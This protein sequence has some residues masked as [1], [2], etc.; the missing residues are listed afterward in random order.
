MGWCWTTNWKFPEGGC[1]RCLVCI[2]IAG[3]EHRQK[4]IVTRKKV[5]NSPT[6]SFVWLPAKELCFF[7]QM[8]QV[9][10]VISLELRGSFPSGICA[11]QTGC[12]GVCQ[13]VWVYVW[14]IFLL[15]IQWYAALMRVQVK[16]MGLCIL[17]SYG[18]IT[19]HSVYLYLIY[20]LA[21][22]IRSVTLWQPER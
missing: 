22:K 19:Q 17:L 9:S 3:L 4:Q 13:F 20:Y 14:L 6:H 8:E 12:G 16:K 2:A 1:W 15:L 5:K 21:L 7:Q 11:Y 18:S 10:S